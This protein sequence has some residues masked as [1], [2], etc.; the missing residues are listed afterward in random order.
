M[1]VRL[2]NGATGSQNLLFQKPTSEQTTPSNKQITVRPK[3]VEISTVNGGI[4]LSDGEEGVRQDR[5]YEMILEINDAELSFHQPT[6]TL[7]L[8]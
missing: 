6:V 7:F 8:S 3:G 4:R 5:F 1:T 2:V